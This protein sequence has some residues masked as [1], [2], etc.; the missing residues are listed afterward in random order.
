MYRCKPNVADRMVLGYCC[1]CIN[2]VFVTNH[3]QQS[4]SF[5]SLDLFL[6]IER[7]ALIQ[8]ENYHGRS[9]FTGCSN[10]PVNSS[11][12]LGSQKSNESRSV[13]VVNESKR[14]NP[15]P[16][17]NGSHFVTYCNL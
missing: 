16:F 13:N 4:L 8:L 1:W 6:E 12:S 5:D 3:P 10:K 14:D 11:S 2:A 17:C 15:R 9:F 7:L